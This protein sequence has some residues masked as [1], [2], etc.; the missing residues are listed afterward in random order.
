M[1]FRH[2]LGMP[3]DYWSIIDRLGTIENYPL[4]CTKS[5]YYMD[6]AD[7]LNEMSILS[8]D[9]YNELERLVNQ[10]D[11]NW[12]L[13]RRKLEDTGMENAHG[14]AWFD[15]AVSVLAETRMS[16]LLENEGL[17]IAD[18]IEAERAR[19]QRAVMAL[20]KELQF[21]LFTEVFN[22]LM[23]FIQLSMAFEVVCTSIEELE[24][25]HSFRERDGVPQLPQSAY[26]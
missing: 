22:Y 6:Y 20:T 7:L 5:D 24:R 26:L 3:L 18:D 17:Y 14:A 1:D 10:L 21:F 25:L 2:L 11:M 4:E 19:R 12:K 16:V 9:L 23:R 13:P 8:A 15:M